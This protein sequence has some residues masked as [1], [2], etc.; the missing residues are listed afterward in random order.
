MVKSDQAAA[1]AGEGGD[2]SQCRMLG[3]E[4]TL[5]LQERVQPC[6]SERLHEMQ[7]RFSTAASHGG[8]AVP[9]QPRMTFS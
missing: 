9:E 6:Q 2:Y 5:K 4:S 8:A 7:W 3:R 1:A